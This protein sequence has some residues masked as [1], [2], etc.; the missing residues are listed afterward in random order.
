MRYYKIDVSHEELSLNLK[1]D[2]E[3]TNAYNIISVS[4]LYGLDGYG[5]H[6]SSDEIIS[7]KIKLPIIVHVLKN[8]YY[9]FIVIYEVNNNYLTVMD[10]SVDNIRLDIE[11]FRKIYLNTCI[12]LYPVKKVSIVNNNK[13]L[14]D[15]IKIYLK[16]ENKIIYKIII[17]SFIIVLF[18]LLLNTYTLILID[19]LIPDYN[20]KLLITIALIFLLLGCYKSILS[21]YKNK[22]VIYFNKKISNYL[23]NEVI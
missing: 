10:P 20:S 21:Y 9:H 12:I 19:Y 4:K 2:R 3:G 7:G 6:Y 13:R 18:S 22:L 1:M 23:N 11:T 14:I 17:Y 15:V 5:I 8:N 16:K